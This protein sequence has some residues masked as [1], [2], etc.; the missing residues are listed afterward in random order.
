MGGRFAGEV[1]GVE[2]GDG[3][4]EVVDVENDACRGSVVGVDLDN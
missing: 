2:L 4:V 3:G 1:A